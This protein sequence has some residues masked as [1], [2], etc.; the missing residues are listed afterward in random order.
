MIRRLIYGPLDL[1]GGALLGGAARAL[2]APQTPLLVQAD[3]PLRH[4]EAAAAAAL[5]STPDRLPRRPTVQ[6]QGDHLMWAII[7]RFSRTGRHRWPGRVRRARA[8]A[9][10]PE[11]RNAPLEEAERPIRDALPRRR[12]RTKTVANYRAAAEQARKADAANAARVEAEQKANQ[13][14]DVP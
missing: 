9:R 6:R 12:P 13:R 1:L 5:A 8:A 4:L 2:D 7:L 11:G 14:K 10:H 3:Y